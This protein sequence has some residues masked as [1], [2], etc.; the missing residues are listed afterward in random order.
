MSRYDIAL[1]VFPAIERCRGGKQ[2]Q[3]VVSAVVTIFTL[4]REVTSNGTKGPTR[5]LCIFQLQ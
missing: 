5:G 1:A 3:E 4:L 2:I